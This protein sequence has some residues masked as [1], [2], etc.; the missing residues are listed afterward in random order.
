MRCLLL[1]I[2]LTLVGCSMAMVRP[3]AEKQTADIGGHRLEYVV[4][5]EGNPVIVFLSGYG[6]DIDTSW[7]RV[8]P[9]VKT[10]STT[11]AYNRFNYGNSDKV[12]APQ[13]GAE[14]VASLQ[15][16]LGEKGLSP[17]YV[18]V[19]HSLGGVYAQLFARQ[20]PKEISGVV[21]IDSSHPD[22]E[23]MRRAQEGAIRRA[24][25]GTIYWIDSVTQPRRHTEIT[26][27]AET[28]SQIRAAPPFP[29]V[30]LIVIS[31][32]KEPP[33]WLVGDGFSQIFQENQRRLVALSPQGRQI[34]AQQSGHFVQN[35]EPEL[36][37][38]AIR[39]VVENGRGK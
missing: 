35:D 12:D 6:A 11:I 33:S 32:G 13:T 1:L 39:E 26:A 16:L 14:I 3:L 17:P 15:R 18:L 19:G 7:G 2:P 23:E 21:L 28:A 20:Y 34:I 36:V 25:S 31:A 37:V 30:P 27:F 38:Q 8:F 4:A 24:L 5:G 10:F 9:E 29:D 22:Q